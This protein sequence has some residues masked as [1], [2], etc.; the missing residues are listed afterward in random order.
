MTAMVEATAGD[1]VLA[2]AGVVAVQV[3][4]VDPTFT[5]PTT[6]DGNMTAD[7]I[8]QTTGNVSA[9]FTMSSANS[10][11]TWIAAFATAC[12]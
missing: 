1:V 5:T 4:S 2:Y 3:T 8:V 12:P 11:A 6:C 10:W 9:S 7:A